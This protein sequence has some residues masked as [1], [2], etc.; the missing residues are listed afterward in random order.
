MSNTNTASSADLPD[1]ESRPG[2]AVDSIEEVMHHYL[3]AA[4]VEAVYGEPVRSGETLVVPAA[5]VVS[6]FGFGMGSGSGTA[7]ANV[8]GSGGGGGG[9][10]GGRVLS[11]PVAVVVIT[12]GAVRVEPVVDVTK[13]GLAALTA[14]GFMFMTMLRM[15]SRR[16]ALPDPEAE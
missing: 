3:E 1:T 10:G 13:L 9:G 12:P 8:G 6:V 14:F 2:N 15:S 11:R 16:R 5:E 7:A 4:T